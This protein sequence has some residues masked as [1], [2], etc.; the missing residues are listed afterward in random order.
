MI[1]PLICMGQGGWISIWGGANMHRYDGRYT[2]SAPAAPVLGFRYGHDLGSSFRFII[3]LEHEWA[4]TRQ[5]TQSFQSVEFFTEV[6]SRMNNLQLLGLIR[7]KSSEQMEL[8]AMFGAVGRTYVQATSRTWSSAD[9]VVNERV[10]TGND[11]GGSFRLQAG[12]RFARQLNGH[13][14]GFAE[15]WAGMA[16]INGEEWIS[17]GVAHGGVRVPIPRYSVGLNVG[18]EFGP[19]LMPQKAPVTG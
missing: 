13:L 16:F 11:I 8:R 4:M 12:L 7:I 18:L 15:G 6:S 9:T 2:I 3:G 10:L 17:F 19:R 1:S 14:Y 5:K